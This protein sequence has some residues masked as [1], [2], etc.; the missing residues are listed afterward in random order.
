MKTFGMTRKKVQLIFDLTRACL[1]RSVSPSHR[2]KGM[3]NEGQNTANVLSSRPVVALSRS[4][5]A[6]TMRS[7]HPSSRGVEW[8]P[9]AAIVRARKTM[10]HMSEYTNSP[11]SSRS[12]QRCSRARACMR[13]RGRDYEDNDRA[14]ARERSMAFESTTVRRR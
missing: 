10:C 3:K 5:R 6:V 7:R 11:R 8:R 13:S 14:R 4:S 12:P 1:A 9:R 2:E